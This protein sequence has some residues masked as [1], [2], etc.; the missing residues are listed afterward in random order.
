MHTSDDTSRDSGKDPVPQKILDV[1][2]KS[3]EVKQPRQKFD[4]S[5]LPDQAIEYAKRE[6]GVS[7]DKLADHFGMSI[8]TAYKLMRILKNRGA[9]KKIPRG[10][11]LYESVEPRQSSTTPS[12]VRKP[13]ARWRM[14]IP[15]AQEFAAKKKGELS[16]A[17][18]RKRLHVS[19]ETGRELMAELERNGYVGAY[20]ARTHRRSA[21]DRASLKVQSLTERARGLDVEKFT[22]VRS[23]RPLFDTTHKEVL[24]SIE[25]DIALAI[26]IRAAL[27]GDSK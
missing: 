2:T 10:K 6:G 23:L 3:S 15:M 21:P 18:L 19:Q 27:T 11:G 16:V 22:F 8:M 5:T 9:L 1:N 24:D 26:N 12:G 17:S 4:W 20:S 13:A 14:L 7:R 25:K